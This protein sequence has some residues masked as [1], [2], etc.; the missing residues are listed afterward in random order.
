VAGICDV[1]EKCTGSSA[2]CPG[3]VFAPPTQTCRASVGPCDP[4]EKCSGTAAACPGDLNG[5]FET[6]CPGLTLLNTAFTYYNVIAFGSFTAGTGDIEQRL[7]VG[8]NFQVG[9]GWSLGASI[10]A[11]DGNLAYSLVVN[12][13]GQIGSGAILNEAVFIGG[14]F[15]EGNPN[16]GIAALVTHCTPPV[17]GCLTSQ[18]NAAQQCY[19]GFQNTLALNAD[20][21]AHL[22]QWSG[23]SVTCNSPTATTYYLTLTPAEM[24]LFTWTTLNGCNTNAKWV[25]KIGGTGDVTFSGGSF[26]APANQVIYNII[27]SGRLINVGATQVAGSVLAP[28]N[29]I[30]QP[31][32]DINGKVIANNIY[33]RQILDGQCYFPPR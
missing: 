9:N 17:G 15:T 4:A 29:N 27:G 21:V 14:T 32:G 24:D 25:I 28:Y 12:G 31:S 10:D 30:Y 5:S 16:N 19:A 8:G 6:A 26:P 22:I 20:N 23:L 2:A 3:D 13:N 1:A 11:T 33:S 7:A 18:F